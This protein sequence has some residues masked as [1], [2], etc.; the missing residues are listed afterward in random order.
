MFFVRAF[1]CNAS[2][3]H[4]YQNINELWANNAVVYVASRGCSGS[5]GARLRLSDASTSARRMQAYMYATR[6]I[7]IAAGKASAN[8]SSVACSLSLRVLWTANARG[9][10]YCVMST[11]NASVCNNFWKRHIV[12]LASRARWC[13]KYAD[14]FGGATS[15]RNCIPY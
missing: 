2:S 3:S 1:K 15:V 13:F 14:V 7:Y 10:P 6:C 4:N 12:S 5:S 8:A 11:R 9:E